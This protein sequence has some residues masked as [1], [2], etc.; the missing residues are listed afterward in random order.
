[1]ARALLLAL[2]ALAGGYGLYSLGKRQG[3]GVGAGSQTDFSNTDHQTPA[4]PGASTFTGW[5][6]PV[7]VPGG[8]I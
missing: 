8:Y 4:P 3:S 6:N 5:Q 2:G 1:M 7:H